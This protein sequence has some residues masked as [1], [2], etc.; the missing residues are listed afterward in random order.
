MI[1]DVEM[2]ENKLNQRLIWPDLARGIAVFLVALGH[3]S[4]VRDE[5]KCLIYTFHMPLFFFISGYFLV[6]KEDSAKCMIFKKAR[7]LLPIYLLVSFGG[8]VLE[9]FLAKEIKWDSLL[10]I[11][12][13]QFGKYDGYL[14]FFV[15]IFGLECILIL[16][17]KLLRNSK[18]VF[19]FCC[20]LAV[21][22]VILNHCV[23]VRLPWHI[24][25]AFLLAPYTGLGIVICKVNDIKPKC[26][27]TAIKEWLAIIVLLVI[28]IVSCYLNAKTGSG[29]IDYNAMITHELISC[30]ISGFS[31]VITLIS[32][33]KM[34]PNLKGLSFVGRN[35]AVYYCMS[36]IGSRLVFSGLPQIIN[37]C[38]AMLALWCIPIPIA[39]IINRWFPWLL[40]RTKAVGETQEK[41]H[42]MNLT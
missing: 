41:Q 38:I 23:N 12:L 37:I 29:H 10:G 34:L 7:S 1:G 39:L 6:R 9:S 18:R 2:I 15:S 31:G 33:C 20:L 32:L 21:C 4:I 8:F 27:N 36:W 17:W 5:Y 25:T 40:G 19:T 16:I 26:I 3:S 13:C 28:Q 11:F 24:D 35:S 22:A 14:W 42:S 30:Y